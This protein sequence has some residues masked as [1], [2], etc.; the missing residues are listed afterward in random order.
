MR[1]HRARNA[2]IEEAQILV[3][4]RHPCLVQTGIL[5]PAARQ[6]ELTRARSPLART[7]LQC[8]TDP[9]RAHAP[10]RMRA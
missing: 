7:D 8:G 10:Q 2:S 3:D 9:Q 1:G 4:D 6:V 5:C